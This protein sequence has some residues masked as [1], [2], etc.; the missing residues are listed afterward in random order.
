[1][2]GFLDKGRPRS[3]GIMALVVGERSEVVA[4]ELPYSECDQKAMKIVVRLS[5][6]TSSVCRNRLY[7]SMTMEDPLYTLTTGH[8]WAVT[9][10]IGA[11][12]GEKVIFFF[13][14]V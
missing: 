1:M 13:V 5:R 14:S 9:S 12:L 6:L 2:A 10:H 7:S 4:A 8:Q 11:N 3:S